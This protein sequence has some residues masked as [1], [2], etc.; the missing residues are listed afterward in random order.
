MMWKDVTCSFSP[1]HAQASDRVYYVHQTLA[2]AEA[3]LVSSEASSGA[4]E[5]DCSESQGIVRAI[6]A[7]LCDDLNTPQAIALL[8]EPLKNLNDLL[9][10]K[11][12][13]AKGCRLP[14]V[15]SLFCEAVKLSQH[16]MACRAR[17]QRGVLPA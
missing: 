17:R 13:T 1:V 3:A 5:Q 9:H 10:T 16:A 14:P 6:E 11:K 7:A 2:D 8:S 4:S 12:V 15:F